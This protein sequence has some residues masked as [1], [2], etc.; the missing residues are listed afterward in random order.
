[1][2]SGTKFDHLRAFDRN[3]GFI[4]EAELQR[5]KR[6]TVAIGGMGGMGGANLMTLVRMGIGGFHI[7]DHD[8]FEMANFNRQ[9]G[10]SMSTLGK[11]KVDVMAAMARDINPELRIKTF[12]SG[13]EARHID[14]F[15]EGVDLFVDGLDFFCID[16]RAKVFRR[17]HEL[18]IPAVTA[19][20][21]G[22]GTSYL[23]F[24][25]EAMSF[26]EYFGLEGRDESEQIARFM[27]GLVP[28]PLHRRYLVDSTRMQPHAHRV[29]SSPVGISLAAAAV[30][31]EATKLLLGRGKVL[32][33]P[34]CHQFD[35]YLGRFIR[36]RR[37][38]SNLGANLLRL[39]GESPRTP[40]HDTAHS[41]GPASLASETSLDRILELARWTP[42]GDNSQ[43]W[44]FEPTSGESVR[45]HLHDQ[46]GND[47]YDYDG[48]PTLVSGGMLLET[49]RLAA[50]RE[51]RELKFE[52]SPSAADG[53]YRIDVSF[54]RNQ[55]IEADPMVDFVH[56]RSVD[57]R[58]YRLAKFSVKH[59]FELESILGRGLE[60][61]WLDSAAERLRFALINA[62]TTDI[63]LRLPEIASVHARVLKFGE[64]HADWGIPAAA[65][66]VSPAMT[67]LIRF[68]VEHPEIAIPATRLLGA[69]APS[70]EMDI[71]PGLFCST[72]FLVSMKRVPE[73]HEKCAEILSAGMRLQKFWLTATALGLSVQPSVAPLCFAYHSEHGR[74][75]PDAPGCDA[76]AERVS[77]ALRSLEPGKNSEHFVFAGRLGLPSDRPPSGRS[78][79]QSVSELLVSPRSWERSGETLFTA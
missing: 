26:E 12:P 20:P 54:P 76:M 6:K 31:A 39:R 75:F 37:P 40:R 7:A 1:M 9:V 2:I 27:A 61:L 48:R 55:A 78:L 67:R 34:W 56:L 15:L 58:P 41:T 47:L 62:R 5:L 19:A 69:K 70:L 59:R 57:R 38:L 60:V 10:A 66:G 50:S 52:C 46:M 42:S 4:T 51:G 45:V 73:P 36:S 22:L 49:M 16:L 44:R 35:P 24:L 13:V 68:A 30:G 33:A 21:V 28:H 32:P 23:V 65:L 63:R 8:T 25:P 14:A 72:H 53:S 71:I 18:G 77:R 17:A 74:R 11:S 29:S 79:R 3:I 43:P 64:T